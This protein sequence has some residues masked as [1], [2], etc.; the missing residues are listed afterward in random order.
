M[1][2]YRLGVA[3][4]RGA[5]VSGLI[6]IGVS[7]TNVSAT[8]YFPGPVTLIPVLGTAL[9]ILGGGG[10]A[11]TIIKNP[12]ES[13]VA[14]A[15]GDWSYSIY[16]RHWPFIAIAGLLWPE[17]PGAIPLAA[18]FS[19]I[20]A[21]GSYYLLEQPVRFAQFST[22]WKKVLL[23]A[24]TVVVPVVLPGLIWAQAEKFE[25][26]AGDPAK[27]PLGYSLG[28]HG[29]G[30]AE[31]ALSVC[32]F[33]PT[34]P[35]GVGSVYLTGDSHAAHFT[36]GIL[37]ASHDAGFPLEILTAS[38]CPL[39]DGVH[40]RETDQEGVLSQCGAWQEKALR[41]LEGST[42]GIVIMGATDFYWIDGTNTIVHDD[43][44][45]ETRHEKIMFFEQGL[46]RALERL[47]S[48]G[49][50]V[51]VVQTVPNWTGIYG[52]Q[53]DTCTRNQILLGCKQQMPLEVTRQQTAEVRQVV[54]RHAKIFDAVLVDFSNQI[55][56]NGVCE[57]YQ[58]GRWVYRDSTHITNVF[59]ARLAPEWVSIISG[60]ENPP[61]N[62]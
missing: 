56:P 24:L 37:E 47:S 20:P 55:C 31:Q 26:Q 28:C 44:V 7:F 46:A 59:S 61:S 57:T 16:L 43:T 23:V 48:A 58:N 4:A 22:A 21:I 41:Y 38:G 30:S 17:N 19:V 25:N 53:L 9:S 60:A 12:L 51:V 35:S 2:H 33:A 42:P 10:S 54:E 49:H 11:G 14:V 50:S 40:R 45:A 32:D 36:E 8:E 1:R 3:S 5:Y 62:F 15:I 39:L 13:K 52:W 6:L 34:T 27:P 29:P 18:L